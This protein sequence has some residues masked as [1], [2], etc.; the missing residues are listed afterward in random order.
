MERNMEL[1]VQGPQSKIFAAKK[2]S[3]VSMT[4]DE[5]RKLCDK[6]GV[7]Y[8]PGYEQRVLQYVVTNETKD[9][10]GDVVRANGGMYDDYMK[11]PV[12]F[13]S[14][15]YSTPPIGNTIKVWNDKAEKN[16]QAWGLFLDDAVDKSGLSDL[17]F[18]FAKSG[19][20]KACSIGF[21]PL[22]AYQPKD[23]AE[24][25]KLGL[26][27]W[28]V[29]YQ[30]WS[31]LEWSPCGIP[32]NPTALQ[33]TLKS[34]GKL[35]VRQEDIYTAERFRL[36][37]DV[38]LLDM[39]AEKMKLD[40]SISV[41]VEVEVNVDKPEEPEQPETPEEPT[42]PGMLIEVTDAVKPVKPVEP[43]IPSVP[44]TPLQLTL[45]LDPFTSAIIEMKKILD[46][47][48]TVQVTLQEV[49]PLL[50]KQNMADTS[51]KALYPVEKPESLFTPIKL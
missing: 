11:N 9:R 10:Y 47:I 23:D 13:F 28:G 50:K 40:K 5:C 17:I 7:V 38:N 45:N 44:A 35:K 26:G 37:E 43:T 27:K 3:L 6:I 12:M 39:F 4:A 29:E 15:D 8:S 33:N 48:K 36:F 2:P 19:F 22:K 42:A 51:R 25:E 21:I 18:R 31:M 34:I 30:Q 49:L 20:L 41:S 46:E 14:H 32:A 1:A 24:A 16:V